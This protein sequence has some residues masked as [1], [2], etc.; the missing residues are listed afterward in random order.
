MHE[1]QDTFEGIAQNAKAGAVV[2]GMYVDGLGAWPE[3][4]L[5]KRVRVSGRAVQKRYAPVA[6]VNERGEISQGTSGESLDS[7]IEAP[8]WEVVK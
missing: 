8:R 6:T 5:G 7:V 4:V 2:N 3:E 1:L